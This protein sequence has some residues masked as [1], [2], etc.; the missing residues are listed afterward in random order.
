MFPLL[1]ED[2]ED[3]KEVFDSTIEALGADMSFFEL[4]DD[5]YVSFISTAEEE[6]AAKLVKEKIQKN[7]E[8]PAQPETGLQ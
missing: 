1:L 6:Q 2:G 7:L 5:D 4:S 8:F 3:W